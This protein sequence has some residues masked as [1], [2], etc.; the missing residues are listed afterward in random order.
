MTKDERDAARQLLAD[1]FSI[2]SAFVRVPVL[3]KILSVSSNAIYAQMRS[4]TFP[5]AHKRVGHVVVVKFEDLVD[6]YCEDGLG[7]ARRHPNR[8]QPPPLP[9]SLSMSATDDAAST[10]EADVIQWSETTKERAER[11]KREV[12]AKMRVRRRRLGLNAET[13]GR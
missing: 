1:K 6:W 5:V 4:G 8:G 7:S 12:L 2:A 11:I 3:S 13:P 10:A 9:P